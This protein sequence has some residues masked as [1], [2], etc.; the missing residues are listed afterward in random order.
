MQYTV[1]YTREPNKVYINFTTLG[2][3]V[4]VVTHYDLNISS[5]SYLS[6]FLVQN[7]YLQV[8]IKLLI[9]WTDF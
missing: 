9:H 2:L 5:R 3:S 1:V 4:M 6:T 8:Q 7:Q